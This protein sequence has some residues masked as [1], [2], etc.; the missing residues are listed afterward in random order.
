MKKAVLFTCVAVFS[1]ISTTIIAHEFKTGNLLIDHPTVRLTIPGRPG[2]G[3]MMVHNM[4][5]TPDRII[6]ASSPA[7]KRIE[8]HT[9]TMTDGI[10]RM[11]P[12]KGVDIPA[13]SQ[14]PFQSGGFHLM[15]FGLK[16]DVK[17]GSEIPITVVFEKAGALKI[18]A[19]VNALMKKKMKMKHN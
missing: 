1:L 7:A 15:V 3:F 12:V 14:V 19:N 8:I 18:S 2:A 6:S 11:R 13:K 10:M 4:G 5:D 9:H 17:A 16:A